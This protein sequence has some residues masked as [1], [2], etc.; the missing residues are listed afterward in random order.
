MLSSSELLEAT[1]SVF[2][3]FSCH[4]Y[5]AVSQRGASMGEAAQTTAADALSE[6]WL[7]RTDAVHDFYASLRDK[8]LPGAPMWITETADAAAGGNPWASTF[9]DTFRYL[10]QLGSMSRRVAQVVAHNTLAASDYGLLDQL[11]TP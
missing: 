5:G 1:G 6:S 9:T 11:R 8:Y 3:V 4:F 2:E 10:Y 7:S